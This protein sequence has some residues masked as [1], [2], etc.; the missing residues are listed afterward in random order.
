MS[1]DNRFHI[2]AIEPGPSIIAAG[3]RSGQMHFL[4]LNRP[5]PDRQSEIHP[6]LKAV[7]SRT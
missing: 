7:I 1:G 6:A 3:D 4:R 5:V 2:C